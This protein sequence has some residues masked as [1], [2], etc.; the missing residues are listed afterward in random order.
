MLPPCRVEFCG[1]VSSQHRRSED[2]EELTVLTEGMFHL[3]MLQHSFSC[4]TTE[5]EDHIGPELMA[6]ISVHQDSDDVNVDVCVSGFLSEIKA[7]VLSPLQMS[8]P[9]VW[10][11]TVW[12]EDFV[13]TLHF[14]VQCVARSRLLTPPPW[15]PSPQWP[16][17]T[18]SLSSTVTFW[19]VMAVTSTGIPARCT[20]WPCRAPA[21][22]TL[23]LTDLTAEMMDL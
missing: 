8:S 16:Y 15:T 11:V 1:S 9:A 7:A 12:S 14:L 3:L 18:P 5:S 23:L 2:C 17:V 20:P 21:S 10:T 19:P 13:L 4:R 6:L 22:C